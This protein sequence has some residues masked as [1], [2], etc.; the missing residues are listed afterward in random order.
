M[1]HCSHHSLSWFSLSV[2]PAGRND[3]KLDGN[4]KT[5]ATP[6]QSQK[7]GNAFEPPS[8]DIHVAGRLRNGAAQNHF[9]NRRPFCW[10]GNKSKA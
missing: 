5:P 2:E 8:H 9:E 3:T 10:Y 6:G 1:T 4:K 7:R